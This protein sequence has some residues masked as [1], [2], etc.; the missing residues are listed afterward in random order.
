M[1]A[2]LEALLAPYFEA[3]PVSVC[4]NLP[5]YITTP[6]L[7]K[8]LESRLPFES[9][10]IMIQAEVADRLCAKAGSKDYGAIT[11]VLGYY[12]EAEKLFTVT[13]D[14]FIPAPK[15]DSSVVRIKLHR[16]K[17][18]NPVDEETFFRT[19]RAS[20]EQ[21]RKTLPNSLASVFGELTKEELT[22]AIVK[23]GF[24]PTVRGEKLGVADFVTLSD[25]IFAR[26]K[27]KK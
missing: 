24:E 27:D 9:I 26:I 23:C 18:Y 3:G 13:A 10:N 15:V 22:D 14:N 20:F 8:L 6:I 4:A 21:R 5:Y 7:M 1:Q 11:A 16:E 25:E 19:I 17:P 12:G 2:D